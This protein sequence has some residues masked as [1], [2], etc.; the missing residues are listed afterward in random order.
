MKILLLLLTCFVIV[1]CSTTNLSAD[2]IT[3]SLSE[4]IKEINEKENKL[5]VND[6]L[7]AIEKSNYAIMKAQLVQEEIHKNLDKQK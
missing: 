1:S 2:P 3:N 4:K 7:F 6:P 5:D